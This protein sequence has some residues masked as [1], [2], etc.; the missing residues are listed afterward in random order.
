MAAAGANASDQDTPAGAAC[1]VYLAQCIHE[2]V[3]K[4]Q[5]PHK[6]VNLIFH[7][8]IVNNKFTALCSVVPDQETPEGVQGF[9]AHKTPPPPIGPYSSPMPGDLW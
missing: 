7:L 2:L 1:R 6:T 5:L 3:L 9:L 4:S 8:V